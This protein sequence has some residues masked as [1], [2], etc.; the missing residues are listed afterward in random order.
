MIGS[1]APSRRHILQIGVAL[2]AALVAGACTD[3]ERPQARPELPTRTGDPLPSADPS[4]DSDDRLRAGAADR[5]RHLLDLHAATL[6]RHPGLADQLVPLTEHHAAHLSAL[7]LS[8]RRRP[9]RRARVATRP[10]AALRDVSAAERLAAKADI[11]ACAR[12]RSPDLARLLASI[13]GCEA[14]HGVLLGEVR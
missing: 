9:R 14:A 13:A 11:A 10:G 12:A 8:A 6:R 5:E 7:D 2:V 3:G 4:V 1:G